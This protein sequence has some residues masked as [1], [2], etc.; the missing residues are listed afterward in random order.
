MTDCVRRII[1]LIDLEGLEPFGR[2]EGPVSI[3]RKLDFWFTHRSHSFPRPR[4]ITRLLTLAMLS[5]PPKRQLIFHSLILQL[6]DAISASAMCF[7]R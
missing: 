7:S 2:S 1:D 3:G 5:E 6:W 4:I